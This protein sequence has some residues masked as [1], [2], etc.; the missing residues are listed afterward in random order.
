MMPVIPMPYRKNYAQ[1]KIKQ[2]FNE[3]KGTVFLKKPKAA[4][5]VKKFTSFYRTQTF[6]TGFTECAPQN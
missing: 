1:D 3:L 4:Q 2:Y 6:I 5:L